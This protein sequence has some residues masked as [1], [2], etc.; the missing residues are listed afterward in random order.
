MLEMLSVLVV[1]AL[2]A[3]AGVKTGRVATWMPGLLKPAAARLAL[4]LRSIHSQQA[5][6]P[7]PSQSSFALREPWPEAMLWTAGYLRL[8]PRAVRADLAERLI[9]SLSQIRRGSETS[10]FAVPPELAA[11]IGCP[12]AEFPS[13]LRSLGLKPAEKDK[14]TGAVK[15]WRFASQRTQPP[16]EAVNAAPSTPS[17]GP[18]AALAELIVAPQPQHRR[19]RRKPRPKAPQTA[20]PK[21][22]T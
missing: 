6:R 20:Q 17:T 16:R 10:A 13:I 3:A 4:A 15:R 2:L 12:I 11:Q 9:F 8:G 14:A 21:T 5:M 1:V 7:A 22:A 18:F 19:R